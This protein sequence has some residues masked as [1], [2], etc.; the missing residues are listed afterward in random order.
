MD[1]R[2]F[3]ALMLTMLFVVVWFNWV[4]PALF[5]NLF[6]PKNQQA[7]NAADPLEGGNDEG[8]AAEDEGEGPEPEALPEHP[9]LTV[10]L[11]SD[12][13]NSD[14]YMQVVASTQGASL[15]TAE[16]N[17]PNFVTLD[18]K[19]PLSILRPVSTAKGKEY[20]TLTLSVPT[21][22]AQL[23]DHETSLADLDWE[24]VPDSQTESSVAFQIEYGGFRLIKTFTLNEG[25]PD[26]RESDS[27]GY[28]VDVDLEIVNLSDAKREIEYTW[29]GPVGV[30]QENAFNARFLQEVKVGALEDHSNRESI[31]LV[32]RNAQMVVDQVHE[33][34]EQNDE[35]AID[36][37]RDPLAYV[38]VD[39]QY[40]AAL[41]VPK[42]DVLQDPDGD[43]EPDPTWHAA[44]PRLLEENRKRGM[45]SEITVAVRSRKIPLAAQGEG[46]DSHTNEFQLY[47]GPKRENILN[48]FHAGQVI[49]Y[50]WNWVAPVSRLM[51][52]V[53]NFFHHS[54]ALPY[55]LAIILLTVCVKT[56]MLPFSIKT[57][58]VQR[59]QK[60]LT[61]ELNQ[62]KEKYKNEPEK[63]LKAQRELFHKHGHRPFV[64]GCL[65]SLLMLPIYMG[66]FFGLDKAF[67]LRLSRFLWID[68]LAA[69]DA[70]FRFPF[71]IFWFG[72]DFNLLPVLTVVLMIVQQKYFSPPPATEEQA[73]Q[74]KILS[75]TMVFIGLMFWHVAAGLCLYFITQNLWGM[76]ERKL[77]EYLRPQ[78]VPSAD[79]TIA[80][81]PPVV[82]RRAAAEAGDKTPT[83][84]QRLQAAADQARQESSLNNGGTSRTDSAS[85]S[86]SSDKK[87]KRRR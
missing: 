22:D 38:G 18:R 30:P 87:S 29:Q 80:V 65:P 39:V 44:R 68:N 59:K 28:F 58:E 13:P 34:Q 74:M 51:L 36:T 84:W 55:A 52:R 76:G 25:D 78:P 77:L 3:T 24:I 8:P 15:L 43:G 12:D 71:E 23:S 62:I 26:G 47:L 69:P 17:D 41:M 79:G 61:P 20:R 49:S 82:A 19:G 50:G 56:I 86:S 66:L 63:F 37:W 7:Q 6:N 21:I 70:L 60:M 75:Y 42:E 46:N 72:W 54:L 4:V 16:F 32:Q 14:Y 33:A 73:M 11:G 9:R 57:A 5:P 85:R 2:R 64:Y 35:K 45:L 48:Q 27:Q 81:T 40:F 1:N 53:L 31:T 83:F 10:E 67:D